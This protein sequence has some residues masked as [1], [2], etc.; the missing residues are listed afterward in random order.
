MAIIE[1]LGLQIKVYISG[2]MAAEYIDPAPGVDPDF[3]IS[4][5]QDNPAVPTCHR[6]IESFE[7]TEFSVEISVIKPDKPAEM[8]TKNRDQAY[9][10]SFTID[11]SDDARL[12]TLSH[13]NLG[14]MLYGVEN[15]AQRTI[16]KFKF[17]R[18][19]THDNGC[20]ETE[21]E[22]DMKAASNMGRIRG[23]VYRGVV[24]PETYEIRT[25]GEHSPGMAQVENMS[26]TEK[27]LKGRAIHHATTLSA[28]TPV[29]W[30]PPDRAPC[31]RDI[32]PPNAPVAVF[33]F[34]YR[35]RK[36][37][38]EEMI[39]PRNDPLEASIRDGHVCNINVDRDGRKIKKEGGNSPK[40]GRPLLLVRNKDGQEVIDLTQDDN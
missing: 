8:W 26:L 37:L 2:S 28:E 7:D 33:Y 17:T 27:A 4:P 29:T 22:Q 20:T 12:A 39:V 5:I 14:G 23:A 3:Q 32:D 9:S 40:S 30:A 15:Y 13:P 31:I 10:F 16:K 21:F 35:S 24:L 36:A 18:L 38:E 6:Y 25:L 11:G 19:S 34:K 1:H